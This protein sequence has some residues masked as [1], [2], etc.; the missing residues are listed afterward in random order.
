MN[1]PEVLNVAP[2]YVQFHGKWR[3]ELLGGGHFLPKVKLEGVTIG[4]CSLPSRKWCHYCHQVVT[5]AAYG[6]N[7]SAISHL[8]ID[9]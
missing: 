6:V 1:F 7:S 3:C 5:N 4:H 9:N 8:V 2:R